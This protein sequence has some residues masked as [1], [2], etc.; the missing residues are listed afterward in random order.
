M[1]S[2]RDRVA[3]CNADSVAGG[4]AGLE[5]QWVGTVGDLRR[6]NL[7]VVGER[8]WAWLKRCVG[9]L[10]GLV[11][12]AADEGGSEIRVDFRDPRFLRSRRERDVLSAGLGSW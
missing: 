2:K 9:A 5:D 1:V 7:D 6:V 4:V 12:V 11:G 3:G 8:F 10:R